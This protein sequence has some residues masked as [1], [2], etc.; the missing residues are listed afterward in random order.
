MDYA[1]FN[2]VAQPGDEGVALMPG[3]GVYDKWSIKWGYQ[4][5]PEADSPEEAKKILDQWVK[6]HE[7]D[8]LYF[9]GRQMSNPLDPRSQTEAIGDDAM[10]ASEYGIAN[11]QVILDNLIEWTS[12]EGKDYDQLEELYGQILGQW[13]RYMGHVTANVG[14]V[15]ATPKTADQDGVVYEHV[16]AE[17]QTRAVA[18]LNQELF[19]TPEWLV[20][21]EVLQRIEPAGML[22]RVRSYQARTLDNLLS[23]QRLARVLENEALNG[24]AAYSLDEMM[25][26]LRMGI[27]TEV[28]SRTAI[29]PYRR[30]LQRA[31]L[32]GMHEL[33]H[34][35]PSP[36]PARYRRFV[37]Y[38]PIDLSQSDIR[39]VVRAELKGMKKP[40][41]KAAKAASDSRT[42]AH[43]E[44]LLIRIEKALDSEGARG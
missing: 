15:Y 22:D 44:D 23:T 1:R 8:S 36:V 13:N 19:A 26:E 25:E 7:G 14:G 4:P 39:A 3:I 11:L 38:T 43:L 6:E 31:Y 34:K 32:E 40:I 33:L 2:Y 35:E 29:D 21:T 27:F 12:E 20:N 28:Y 24:G 5:I 41:A 42:Q 17:V 37:A 16:P 18:F 30:S 9:Y 10:K